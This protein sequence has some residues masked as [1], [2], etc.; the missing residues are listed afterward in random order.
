M[1]ERV[2]SKNPKAHFGN[3]N[4]TRGKTI[5]PRGRGRPPGSR[6]KSTIYKERMMALDEAVANGEMPHEF[7][8]RVLRAKDDET[9]Y[10][11]RITWED[12]KWAAEKSANYFAPK[13]TSTKIDATHSVALKPT[14]PQEAI[15]QLNDK[16]DSLVIPTVTHPTVQ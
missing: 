5:G 4:G 12:R 7:M 9:I 8:L 10:G 14:T 2:R 13:L 6:N 3:P 1:V 15:A 11:H 16:L